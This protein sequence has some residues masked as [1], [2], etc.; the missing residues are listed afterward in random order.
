MLVKGQSRLV[1]TNRIAYL[2]K[3]NK[4][5]I[6]ATAQMVTDKESFGLSRV[7]ILNADT[8]MRFGILEYDLCMV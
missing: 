2:T 8:G 7:H 1:I 4:I 5:A 6:L 3:F